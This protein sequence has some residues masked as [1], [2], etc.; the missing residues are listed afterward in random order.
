[1][2]ACKRA[3]QLGSY[4]G[5]SLTKLRRFNT[6]KASGPAAEKL[7]LEGYW[8]NV[9][10]SSSSNS[11]VNRFDSR[12]ISQLAK[13]N[14]KRVFL[15]D[16]LALVKFT[17]FL[18]F[19]CYFLM[20]RKGGNRRNDEHLVVRA[21]F[22]NLTCFKLCSSLFCLWWADLE[23]ALTEPNT[24][25]LNLIHGEPSRVLACSSLVVWLES[26]ASL[27]KCSSFVCLRNKPIWNELLT[28]EYKFN[29]S[30][31]VYRP[32]KWQSEIVSPRNSCFFLVLFAFVLNSKKLPI[33]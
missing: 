10:G 6:S 31:F 21:L 13:P 22:G 9:S 20:L 32:W 26:L 12:H 4:S 33:C 18:S 1:M 28:S 23:E 17:T 2:A 14:G 30:W 11:S 5:L 7:Q 3:V 25:S 27:K 29:S 8:T 19:W 15:V 24:S 16:T